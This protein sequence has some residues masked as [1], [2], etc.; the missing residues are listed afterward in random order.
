ML[1][2]TRLRMT[3]TT[4]AVVVAIIIAV[5]L[6]FTYFTFKKSPLTASPN[7]VELTI[8]TGDSLRVSF[9]GDSIDRGLFAS[10]KSLGFHAL[11]VH[12]WRK[13]GPV[14]DFP[15]ESMVGG[16]A[17]DAVE[18][19]EFPKDQQLYVVELGTN[20][21]VRMNYREFRTEYD[22]LLDRI[23]NASPDAALVCVGVWR[24]K[25]DAQ[26]FDTIIKD[27]CEIRDGVFVSISDL[28]EDASLKGPVGVRT[29]GGV[30]DDFHPNDRG[31][32]LIADRVLDVIRLD[33][34][35]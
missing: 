5:T 32:R 1:I 34:E 12:E 14:T 18:N 16:T 26:T 35:A 22:T 10:D 28:S 4:V 24:P 15:M 23:R 8:R 19:P 6:A 7:V 17:R 3:T 31:H 9:V 25:K 27:L 21:E 29:W 30:S 20:D 2:A 33:R 13:S 11:M